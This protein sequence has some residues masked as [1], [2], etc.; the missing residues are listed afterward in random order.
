[1]ASFTSDS[2][3]FANTSAKPISAIWKNKEITSIKTSNL[4]PKEE[5]TGLSTSQ[6]KE[7]TGW[8]YIRPE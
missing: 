1:M 5:L 6:L 4:P 3:I 8:D 2:R 7:I